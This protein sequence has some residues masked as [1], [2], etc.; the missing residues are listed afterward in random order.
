MA[1]VDSEDTAEPEKQEPEP[2]I[3]ESA[4]TAP[5]DEPSTTSEA[6][7]KH[8]SADASSPP[9]STD[10]LTPTASSPDL[11]VAFA[12]LFGLGISVYYSQRPEP[13]ASQFNYKERN[14]LATTKGDDSSL[15]SSWH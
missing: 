14:N 1:A 11:L 9:L 13:G 8:D 3:P 6:P 5:L 2:A 10:T 15:F 7:E 4:E 12:I